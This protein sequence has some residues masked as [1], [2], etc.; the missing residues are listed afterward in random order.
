MACGCRGILAT[1]RQILL[2]GVFSH[3][4]KNGKTCWSNIHDD[5]NYFQPKDTKEVPSLLMLSGIQM[6]N[7]LTNMLNN[8]RLRRYHY[9]EFKS[10]QY[11]LQ[12]D[13]GLLES[14]SQNF[15]KR[16]ILIKSNFI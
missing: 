10:I 14:L 2:N 13:Y 3:P 15:V 16:T 12:E 4:D 6:R 8:K 5:P 9:A 11:E 7:Q 1:E